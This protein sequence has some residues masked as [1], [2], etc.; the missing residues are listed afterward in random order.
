MVMAI[1]RRSVS[2]KAAFELVATGEI[3]PA[4]RAY[5]FGVIQ[6]VYPAAQ[7]AAEVEA[8][9]AR[10][11]SKSASAVMLSKRLL[12][13]M[14]SMSFEAALE[15]GVQTNAIARMTDD[16]RRGVERFLKK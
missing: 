6:R 8:Y 2:E 11:A 10:L 12:Y 7:F 3:V 9:V 4:A 16:C 1:L 5:E 14:D 13:Q 15:A